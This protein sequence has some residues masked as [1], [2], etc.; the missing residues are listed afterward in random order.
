MSSGTI[1][2][3]RSSLTLGHVLEVKFISQ[4]D[5]VLQTSDR[6]FVND[7]PGR[8]FQGPKSDP[9]QRALKSHPWAHLVQSIA[10]H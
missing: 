10:I 6:A 5:I 4:V 1:V 2:N 3:M 9:Y 8:L 7:H